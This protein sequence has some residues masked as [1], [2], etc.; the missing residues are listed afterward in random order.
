VAAGLLMVRQHR[1][2]S[3]DDLSAVDAAFFT[4][5]G[6]LSVAMCLLFLFA[7]MRPAL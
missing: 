6:V 2:V 1:L 4:A 7:K 3:P 5:N